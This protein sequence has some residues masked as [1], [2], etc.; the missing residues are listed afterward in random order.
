MIYRIYT[1]SNGV[2]NEVYI[3]LTKQ[4]LETR[5]RLHIQ[6]SLSYTH[7][8]IYQ[9]MNK[10]KGSVCIELIE[11]I[12]G[13]KNEA[14]LVEK[15]WMEQFRQW[16]FN[17]LNKIGAVGFKCYTRWSDEV[18]YDIC[19]KNSKKKDIPH[20]YLWVREW[21]KHPLYPKSSK[22]TQEVLDKRIEIYNR[23]LL[24]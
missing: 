7:Y 20:R 22:T 1:L 9:F 18:Y 14:I 10:N 11:I 13:R 17:V 21:Q 23:N 4:P 8:P 6:D 2:S 24:W 19:Y 15:Y 3:G 5:F 16:G 12:K